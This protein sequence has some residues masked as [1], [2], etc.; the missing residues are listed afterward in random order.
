[1]FMQSEEQVA[2]R[3]TLKG[4]FVRYTLQSKLSANGLKEQL[5]IDVARDSH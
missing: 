3:S 5:H 1:M 4:D 2:I